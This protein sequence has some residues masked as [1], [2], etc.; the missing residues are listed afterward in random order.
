[1]DSVQH[2][3]TIQRRTLRDGARSKPWHLVQ[4]QLGRRTMGVEARAGRFS[5]LGLFCLMVGCSN[6]PPDAA[7]SGA[8]GGAVTAQAGAA[9]AIGA[10]SGQSPAGWGQSTNAPV[11][12]E[13]TPAA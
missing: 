7:T 8:G 4:R 5:Q 6:S 11:P 13:G 9:A 12:G 3:P 10:A 2:H 1:M